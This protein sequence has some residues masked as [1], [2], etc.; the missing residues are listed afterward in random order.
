MQEM[1]VTVGGICHPLPRP[2]FVLATRNPI[3]Q[4]GTYRMPEGQL[5]R[6]MVMLKVDYP[7]RDDELEIVRRTTGVERPEVGRAI[8]RA[9]LD[10][11]SGVVR[12]MPVADHVLA[13]AI[14][15]V[16]AT[17]PDMPDAPNWLGESV[18]YGAGPRAG[19]FLVLSAKAHEIGRA[20]V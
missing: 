13:A 16:R 3:E 6:F 20:H 4:E 10:R 19:Q 2:F 14:D 18:R 17:R 9:V 15:L 5:D 11:A 8:D 1:Q 12:A 7:S